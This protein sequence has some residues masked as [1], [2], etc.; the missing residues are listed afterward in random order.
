MIFAKPLLKLLLV[1]S[2]YRQVYVALQAWCRAATE[3][4][5]PSATYSQEDDVVEEDGHVWD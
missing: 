2:C 3:Y 5:L 1:A 4:V